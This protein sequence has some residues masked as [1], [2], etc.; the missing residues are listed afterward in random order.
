M[1][2]YIAFLRAINVGGHIVKMDHLRQ[3]FET[4]GF[5]NVDT[6]I[7]SGNVIFDSTSKNAKTLER[8]IETLL[9]ETLGYPVATFIRSTSEL[10]SIARYKPFGESELNAD[11]N[12]LYIIFTADELSVESKRKLRTFSSEVDDFH[13]NGREVY[14]LSR[15]KISESKISGAQ[16]ERTMEMPGTMRNANTVKR[17]AAKYCQ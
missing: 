3:L 1:P 17:L 6:F 11:G 12:T 9:E 2:K 10:A 15:K 14:W 7:A 8:K 4:L 13:A 16:L 5:D